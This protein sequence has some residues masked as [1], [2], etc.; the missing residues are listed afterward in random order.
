MVRPCSFLA[1]TIVVSHSGEVPK[2]HQERN[3]LLITLIT[4]NNVKRNDSYTTTLLMGEMPVSHLVS[5]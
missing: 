1:G 3:R 2:L 5:L 4:L